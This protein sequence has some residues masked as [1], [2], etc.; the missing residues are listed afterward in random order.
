[1]MSPHFHTQG[2]VTPVGKRNSSS[3]SAGPRG[4]ARGS[5]KAMVVLYLYGGADTFNMVVPMDCPRYSEYQAIRKNLALSPDKLTRITTT[6]QTC[7]NFGIHSRLGI[8]K[9]LYDAREAAFVT[10]VGT[11]IE[12]RLGNPNAKTCP[13]LFSHADMIHW[14]QTLKCQKGTSYKHG[15]GGRMADALANGPNGRYHKVYSFSL[16]GKAPWSEGQD[17]R[18][19]VISGAPNSGTT[20]AADPDPA[21]TEKGPG[22]KPGATVQKIIDNMTSI[23]FSSIYAKEYVSQLDESV[24]S[25]NKVA[26]AL[27]TGAKQ[28]KFPDVNYGYYMEPLKQT[29][30]LIA[31]R[32]A[33]RATRDF[34]FV[35]FHGWDMHQKIEQGL[36]F[37]FNLINSGVTAFVN[38]MK[39]QG[40]WQDVVFATQSDFG[41]TLDPNVRR[42]SDHA[43]AGQHFVLSGSLR[44][45][46]I[47]NDYPFSLAAGNPAD[48][49]RGRLIPKYPWESFMVPIAKWLGVEESQLSTVFPNLQNWNSSFIIPD[50]F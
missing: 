10:N 41:R 6:G 4:G 38:E 12:P 14:S 32:G 46:K 30:R 11:L 16:A 17:T 39:A 35:G 25:F 18:R 26:E 31:S 23:E 19:R 8:I 2:N 50:L 7:R 40:V 43:W 33:R 44:G 49:G 9:E 20:V 5:Y 24:S 42:G 13:S 45:G 27:Q 22:F 3:G 36:N 21:E 34:Y 48:I 29:A 28:L 47:Y 37:N 1:M 15:G